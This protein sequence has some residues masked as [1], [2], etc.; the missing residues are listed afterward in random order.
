MCLDRNLF[1]YDINK[2][3][4]ESGSRSGTYREEDD[5]EVFLIRDP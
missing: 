1:K 5:A 2:K 3:P 4:I